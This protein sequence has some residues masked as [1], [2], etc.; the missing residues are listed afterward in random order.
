M[1]QMRALVMHQG[2]IGIDLDIGS[3]NSA[4]PPRAK[5]SLLNTP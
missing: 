4:E 1:I 2:R 3:D 5:S